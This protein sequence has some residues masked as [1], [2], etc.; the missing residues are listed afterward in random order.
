MVAQVP[1][2][3]QEDL[4]VFLSELKPVH[5]ITIHVPF[6]SSEAIVAAKR[7]FDFREIPEDEFLDATKAKMPQI[8]WGFDEVRVFRVRRGD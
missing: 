5:R 2:Y 8:T 7:K 3:G 4:G 6:S 1:W